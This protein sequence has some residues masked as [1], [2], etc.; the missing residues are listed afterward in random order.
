MDALDRAQ[1]L[2][3]EAKQLSVVTP[4]SNSS[5]FTPLLL[6][7]HNFL[8]QFQLHVFRLSSSPSEILQ[9]LLIQDLDDIVACLKMSQTSITLQTQVKEALQIATHLAKQ[10]SQNNNNNK[11]VQLIC[12]HALKK[13]IDVELIIMLSSSDH[14]KHLSTIFS[15]LQAWLQTNNNSKILD[16]LNLMW[17][18]DV[19]MKLAKCFKSCSN[20]IISTSAI[21]DFSKEFEFW[22]ALIFNSINNKNSKS[23]ITS[24]LDRIYLTCVSICDIVGEILNNKVQEDQNVS[25]LNEDD[26]YCDSSST[27]SHQFLTSSFLKL[28][29]GAA[30]E[31]LLLS[32]NNNFESSISIHEALNLIQMVKKAFSNNNNNNYYYTI[33]NSHSIWLHLVSA[34]ISYLIEKNHQQL[35]QEQNDCQNEILEVLNEFYSKTSVNVEDNENVKYCSKFLIER[36]FC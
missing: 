12:H 32:H 27:N 3:D 20:N 11:S 16:D 13:L 35:H 23:Q 1:N 29:L 8:L 18:S 7:P 31:F 10:H 28:L 15:M 9:N 14:Q 19:L 30:T 33:L 25:K 24:T 2:L 4:S 21:L 6:S 22:V 34:E 17:L 26:D 36:I 5:S